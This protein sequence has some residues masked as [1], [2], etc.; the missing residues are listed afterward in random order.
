MLVA[1]GRH[2][3]FMLK[4]LVGILV[5]LVLGRGR[6]SPPAAHQIIE[7]IAEFIVDR[8]VRLVADHEIEMPAG[9]ELSLLVLRAVNDVV[10]GLVG[11]KDACAV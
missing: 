6:Q 3:V 1:V 5:D 4:D 7:N 2:A 8:A 11:R 10:H 9:K